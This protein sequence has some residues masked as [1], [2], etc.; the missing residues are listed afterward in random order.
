M[1]RSLVV[2]VAGVCLLAASPFL[3]GQNP[4]VT[5][6]V[7]ALANR[8]SINPLIYGV[9]LF[10]SPDVTTV[11]EDL[12]CPINRYGGNRASTYN[13]Q[14]NSDNRGND[15]FFESISDDT[16]TA[17][18]R[19]DIFITATKAASSEPMVTIPMLDWIA[20]A[21]TEQP[22]LCSYPSTAFP[23]QAQFDMYDPNCGDGLNPDLSMIDGADP[24]V[25]LTP[26]SLAT[27][28][29]WIQ[30]IIASHGT[31][32]HGGV[33]Y[34]MLDNEHDLW[35]STHHDATPNAPHHTDDL[36]R[37]MIY[38]ET[39]K[40]L[41][42][43]ALVVGPEMSGWLGYLLSPA[44]YEYGQN[45]GWAG[46][47]YGGPDHAAM[48]DVDYAPWLLSQFQAF[49]NSH[50][51]QRLID[52]FTV[53]YYPQGGD[54]N[55]NTRSLWD[56]AYTDPSW[57]GA[58]IMLIPRMKSWVAANYPGTKIGITEYNWGD[59]ND[60]QDTDNMGYAVNQAD[61]LGI[62]GREGLD[63]ATRFNAPLAGYPSYNAMKMYRNYDGGNSTFG[64]VSVS[65]SAPNPDT[66][67]S[68][69]AYR[70]V[71]NKLTVM[72]LNKYAMGNTP[73]TVNVSNFPLSG[74]A[75]VWQLSGS[76]SAIQQLPD[77]TI[78]SSS[79][80]LTVPPQSITLLVITPAT[81]LAS[82]SPTTLNFGSQLVRSYSWQ[83]TVTVTNSGSTA[84]ALSSISLTGA[85]LAQINNCPSSLAVGASCAVSI[86]PTTAGSLSGTL[87]ITDAAPDSPQQVTISG[88]GINITITPGRPT[89]GTVPTTTAVAPIKRKP[90]AK[91]TRAS[92]L[93]HQVDQE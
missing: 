85:G 4:A 21:G 29:A 59:I 75:Q 89:R 64:D 82:V 12:N 38:A 9:N 87:T 18:A 84:L 83:S 7:D 25:A 81:V 17:G 16:T 91:T 58:N 67:A 35:W 10:E 42:P 26:N 69:A 88:T 47:L 14:L 2:F 41:D 78:S 32:A 86:A 79:V 34:Y 66:V 15:Y 56:P 1:K 37:M 22:F 31:S 61:V 80:S 71:D 23:D 65:A 93:L 73:V 70:T 27:Q 48:G 36:A 5:V 54:N 30:D 60:E 13:W 43:N 57:I 72:L 49:A 77:A 62:F 6:S 50:R 28:A 11:L 33:K 24:T 63:L 3:W 90:A 8:H 76:G 39:I 51:G 52:V 92:P 74:K 46:G 44:D 40:W 19:G 55:I 45:T 68:F 20:K 53:H